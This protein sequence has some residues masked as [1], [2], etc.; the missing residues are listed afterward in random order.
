MKSL[1][2]GFRRAARNGLILGLV[3]WLIVIPNSILVLSLGRTVAS[4][5][6]A[7]PLTILGMYL[8]RDCWDPSDDNRKAIDK[9]ERTP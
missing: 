1:V 8:T 6:F 3:L 9:T 4:L 7:I 2:A 5:I